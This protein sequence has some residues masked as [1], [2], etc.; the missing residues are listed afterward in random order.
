MSVG[1]SGSSHVG[2]P[3]V[4]AIL[5][6]CRVL[7]Q[8]LEAISPPR[9]H[10]EATRIARVFA[11]IAKRT[12]D[13][14]WNIQQSHSRP[15]S[16]GDAVSVR[17]LARIVQDLHSYVRYIETSTP[18]SCPP[19][20]Q[21][22]ISEIVDEHV[23]AA[24]GCK[25]T[26][27]IALVRPQWQ[28]NL[29]FVNI[30]ALLDKIE[31]TDLDLNLEVYGPP[32]EDYG[33]RDLAA[34]LWKGVGEDELPRHM[35]ILSFAGLDRDDVLLYPLLAH[36]IGH[37]IDFAKGTLH[38]DQA[39]KPLLVPPTDEEVS[40]RIEACSTLEGLP[41]FGH[42]RLSAISRAKQRTVELAVHCIRELTADL[43]A[44]R[45]LGFPFFVA[46][47]EY[48]K[49]IGS[50]DPTLVHPTTGYP[51][52]RLRLRLVLQELIELGVEDQL[53]SAFPENGDRYIQKT[54]AYLQ[55]WRDILLDKNT[56]TKGPSNRIDEALAALA[57]ERVSSL[58]EPLQKLVRTVIPAGKTPTASK[59]LAL[60]VHLLEAR[61]PPFPAISGCDQ[62]TSISFVDVLTAGWIYEIGCGE[63]REEEHV[64]AIRQHAEYQ[65]TC[66]LIFKALEL[67]GSR[68]A[69]EQFAD[70]MGNKPPQAAPTPQRDAGI[71][72][73]PTIIELVGQ[74]ELGHQLVVVPFY[75]SE[76]VQTASLDIHLGNWFK[77]AR[78]TRRASIDLAFHADRT[79]ALREGQ[80][81]VYVRFGDQ[82]VLH[83]GDF[84]LG[85]SIE[86]VAV[87]SSTMASVEGK[88]S[89]GR[90]GVIIATAAQV[91]PGFKG[92]IVLELFN[93]GTLPLILR[94][95][96]RI[97][98]LVF[99]SMDR[100]L[101]DAWLY[102]GMFRCQVKP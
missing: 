90:A 51:G 68:Q 57:S 83:P 94:P 7:L 82:F 86:Y 65:N 49:T 93:A 3:S 30:W 42:Y 16:N 81:E 63:Q 13:R 44:V 6:Q 62:N 47:A 50:L 66:V 70:S 5:Y 1:V 40:S 58:L 11:V 59:D 72:S 92:C 21:S 88:S 10:D 9:Y 31:V 87:P 22:A 12:E 71:A 64:D 85:V 35:A 20:I 26:D 74:K 4:G 38:E 73:G 77:I 78:R 55:G 34:E 39:I 28:Y 19:G 52:S 45:M 48:L 18:G 8:E 91:A 23:P 75:G 32:T 53:S 89:L 56:Q 99:H 25:R 54:R 76:P 102:S 79:A 27:I 33:I 15:L 61:I 14:L 29:K 98:Q 101:P 41:L 43:L 17:Q 36:E 96:M 37:F 95:G 2:D 60:M 100:I 84:A 46:L 97:A 80:E 69:I 67:R 24:L